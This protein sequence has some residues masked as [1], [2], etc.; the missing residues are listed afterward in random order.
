[1]IEFAFRELE[2]YAVKAARTVLRGLGGSNAAWLPDPVVKCAFFLAC[3]GVFAFF[4]KYHDRKRRIKPSGTA[5]CE[6]DE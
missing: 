3:L 1:V 5:C 2:L 4:C 6:A